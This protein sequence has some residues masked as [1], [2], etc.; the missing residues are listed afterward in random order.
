MCSIVTNC[1]LLLLYFYSKGQDSITDIQLPPC[2]TGTPAAGTPAAGTEN[3]AAGTENP[4]QADA[5]VKR[6]TLSV[7]SWKHI[8]KD[9]TAFRVIFD[10]RNDLKGTKDFSDIPRNMSRL[11]RF[12][13]GKWFTAE[14]DGSFHLYNAFR[15]GKSGDARQYKISILG[16]VLSFNQN[17]GGLSLLSNDVE[18][19]K[20]FFPDLHDALAGRE[21]GRAVIDYGV[22]ADKRET[23]DDPPCNVKWSNALRFDPTE[24]KGKCLHFTASSEGNIFVVF[25][26]LPIDKTSWY[27]IEI[28]PQKVAI[29]KVNNPGLT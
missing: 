17:T 19:S 8:T 24:T 10:M 25:A 4:S 11:V 21:L 27:Y 9:K 23:L 5:V 13:E 3:P 16:L 18:V 22:S 6:S 20:E 14:K 1:L 12:N 2:S 15:N 7:P 28:T 26:T 29:Y